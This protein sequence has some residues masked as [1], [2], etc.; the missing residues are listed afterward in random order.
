MYK[1]TYTQHRTILK[2]VKHLDLKNNLKK[3]LER[4]SLIKPNLHC[5]DKGTL[6][7]TCIN[8]RTFKLN[9]NF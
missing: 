8:V 3:C 1:K 9:F 7:Q 6:G 5:G 2:Y 4:S